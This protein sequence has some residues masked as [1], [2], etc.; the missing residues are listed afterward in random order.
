MN[1]FRQLIR[2]LNK[3]KLNTSVIILSMAVGMACFFLIALFV[4]RELNSDSF[5]RDKKRTFALQSGDPFDSEVGSGSRMMHCREGSAEYMQENFAEVES[6]CRLWYKSSKRIVVN[7]NSYFDNLIILSASANFFDFFNYKLISNNPQNV[8]RTDRDIAISKELAL[9]YFGETLPIGESIKT[10]SG[11]AEKEYIISGVFEK[12]MGSTQISFD[13]VTRFD[14]EDSRCYLKLD[15]QNS[16]QKMESEFER[17]KAEIPSINDGSPNQYYLQSMKDAYFSPIRSAR[18][19]ASRDKADIRIALVIAL[20]IIGTAFFNYIN[21][22]RNRLNDNSNRYT[23]SRIQGASNKDLVKS[24]MNEAIGMLAISIFIA[25][26]LMKLLLPFFNQLLTTDITAHTFI[27]SKSGLVFLLFLA[28][29]IGITYLFAYVN[30]QTQL[31]TARIKGNAQKSKRRMSFMSVVQLAAMIVLVICSSVVIKQIQFINDKEIGLNKKVLEVRIPR[32]YKDRTEVFKEELAA[33]PYIADLSLTTASPLL[34]HWI[35]IFHYQEDGLDKTYYPCGFTGDANYIKTC[36]IKILEGENFS[37]NPEVDKRKCLINKSLANLF[38]N[39]ELVGHPMPG[40]EKT[41]IIGIVKDFHF[42]N[43]KKVIEPAYITFNENGPHILVRAMEGKESEVEA[44][45]GTAW[46]RLI[47]DEPPNIENVEVRYQ[48]MHAEN[49]L[50]I[51]LVGSCCLISIF[52]SMMGLFALSVDKC[53]KRVKEVGIRKVNGAQIF[54]ILTLLNKDFIKWV[55]IAFLIACPIAY[56]AMHK[57][58]ENFAYKTGL[59]WWIFL[60]AGLLTLGIALLTISWQSWRAA[61]L[62]PVKSLRYE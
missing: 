21:L 39:R 44:F 34:E 59:S 20:M 58:L 38:P 54:E 26:G 30:V 51:E 17:L 35:V 7:R 8:L 16:K 29:I 43:L 27:H 28:M 11:K 12:P 55:A 1:Q 5:N 32:A 4:Q 33:N 25:L 40:N 19:E 23:I 2:G 46:D 37:G 61:I 49:E 24:F 60:L 53:L 52:L 18:F 22:I 47:P 41:I 45:I 15:S 56:Y 6:F 14:G 50:F 36:G 42:S 57:W 48:F 13:M 31:S 3:N 62:N 9:K 10:G